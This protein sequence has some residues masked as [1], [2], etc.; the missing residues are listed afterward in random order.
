MCLELK[1][2]IYSNLD[3]INHIHLVITNLFLSYIQFNSKSDQRPGKS[4]ML[5]TTHT[6]VFL[7]LDGV[8]DLEEQVKRLTKEL[9]KTTNELT[10]LEKKLGNAK[11]VDNAPDE[12]ISEVKEKAAAFKE[13]VASLTT[14]IAN[15][16]S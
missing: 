6:E 11:F 14:N 3:A 15:F 8:I 5:A 4:S 13:K 9:D 7:K 2:I 12:V 10:K 16:K 1:N